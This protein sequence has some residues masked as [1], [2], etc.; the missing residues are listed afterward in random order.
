MV[1]DALGNEILVCSTSKKNIFVEIV[2]T[3]LLM[4][5]HALCVVLSF[6]EITQ[7]FLRGQNITQMIR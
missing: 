2:T 3:N 5:L 4:K 6:Q 1:K 7:L